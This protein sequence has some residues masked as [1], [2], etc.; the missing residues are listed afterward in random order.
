[1]ALLKKLPSFV[2]LGLIVPE[3]DCKAWNFRIWNHQYTYFFVF[4]FST[5][6]LRISMDHY[7]KLAAYKNYF[8]SID[9]VL[10]SSMLPEKPNPRSFLDRE[11]ISAFLTKRKRF[12]K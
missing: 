9:D 1:M 7:Y 10:L 5:F 3:F 11:T 2:H 8:N 6:M 4:C 12:R